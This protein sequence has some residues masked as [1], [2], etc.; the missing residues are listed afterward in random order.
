MLVLFAVMALLPALAA[1][2]EDVVKRAEQPEAVAPDAGPTEP[3]ASKVAPGADAG[4]EPAAAEQGESPEEAPAGKVAVQDAEPDGA[5]GSGA[6]KVTPKVVQFEAKDGGVVYW[7][8]IDE[9]IDL[10]LAPFV[11]RVVGTAEADPNAVAIVSEIHTPGGRVD[12]AVRIRDALIDCQVPTV[13]FIHSE[14]ISAGALIALAHD[15]IVTTKAGTIGAATPIQI[16]QGGGDAQ[17]VGEKITSY[18]RGVFRATAEATGR[19]PIVAEAMV[20]ADIAIPGLAPKGKLL[21]ATATE[22][23]EWGIVDLLVTSEAEFLS[24]T[25]LDGPRIERQET[26]W[27]EI[28]ARGLTH[29]VV[30]SLLMSFGFLG[31]LMEL[32]S[33]GFGIVGGIG[34]ACLVLFFFGHYAVHLA[35]LEEM[36]L[37]GAGVLLLAIE[38]FVTPGFGLIGG[39]GLLAIV[40]ALVLALTAMPIEVSFETGELGT[41]LTRVV[42]TLI[43]TFLLAI[44]FVARFAKSGPFK[45]LVLADEITGRAVGFGSDAGGGTRDAA[46]DGQPALGARG[47][48]K[49]DLRPSGKVRIGGRTFD[50]ITGGEPIERGAEIE[51]RGTRNANIIVR[52][53][54]EAAP[55]AE[56][57]EATP[58]DGDDVG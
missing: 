54:P 5:A 51:V 22:A 23:L 52:R 18:V 58:E 35:G 17:P 57:A 14:A 56:V 38:L 20:D 24:K 45:R 44:V 26:N 8:H 27:G 50:A 47:V 9:T 7:L 49:T 33:P 15:Y 4:G 37:F 12:A 16:G 30:S 55:T 25:G 6:K 32:Y 41:A 53:A 29:P 21:T 19:D 43:V 2:A 3:T 13:A 46:D 39:A 48:V 28:I 1:A 36:A 31:I 10:G 42:V 11:E 40:I 34:L